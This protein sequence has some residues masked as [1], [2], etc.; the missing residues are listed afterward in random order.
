MKRAA[1]SFVL[2]SVLLGLSANWQQ[3]SFAAAKSDG[4]LDQIAS[5]VRSK[6]R[7]VVNILID[8]S[9]SLSDT[10]PGNQ[11]V[12][13]IK[14]ALGGLA[15]LAATP[16]SQGGA[17]VDVLLAGFDV[18]YYRFGEWTKISKDNLA[19][20]QQIADG[21]ASRN[22]G[23]DT[24][25]AAALIGANAAIAERSAEVAR[26]GSDAC[27]LLVWFTDGKY[28]I[29]DRT[30]A[31]R[32]RQGITKDYAPDLR[33]DRNGAGAELV[34]RGQRLL[35]DKAGVAD[36]MRTAKISTVVVAL[37]SDIAEPDRAFLRSVAGQDPGG[38]G[39]KPGIG[40]VVG[41][42][43]VDQV[44]T[45][46][47]SAVQEAKGGSELDSAGVDT[48]LCPRVAC[49]AGTRTFVIDP[50]IRQFHILAVT[51]G[52]DIAI[53]LQAP[54]SKSVLHLTYPNATR[55][56]VGAGTISSTWIAPNA[57]VI[58]AES[59]S[60]RPN[61]VG[62]WS[63]IFIDPKGSSPSAVS[64]S[65]IHVFGGLLPVLNGK[66]EFESGST[67]RFEVAVAGE[68]DGPRTDMRLFKTVR[69]R[70]TVTDPSSSFREE[71]PLQSTGGGFRG[72]YKP[73]SKIKSSFVNLTLRLEL[74]TRSGI[75]LAPVLRTY[76]VPVRPPASYPRL[77]PAEINFSSITGDGS[78]HAEVNIVG[79]KGP[80]CV[81][82]DDSA[83]ETF[84]TGISAAEFSSDPPMGSVD[85]CIKV[86]AGQ[87][88][89]VDLRV[90][91]TGQA[92]GVLSGDIVLHLQ[93][94]G[95]D[96]VL[97]VTQPISI[98]MQREINQVRR[99]EIFLLLL[100][101]GLLIPF[102]LLLAAKW[103]NSR[104][105]PFNSFRYL[106]VPIAVVGDRFEGREPG[107]AAPLPITVVGLSYADAHAQGD[108]RKF[109]LQELNFD[110][111]V[112][113][114][115]VKA[116]TG[117][118]SCASAIAI[119]G[120]GRTLWPSGD[121]DVSLAIAPSWLMVI[122]KVEPA[123]SNGQPARVAGSLFTFVRAPGS[124]AHSTLAE[125]SE[126]D[127]E[128]QRDLPTIIQGIIPRL[129]P[130]TVDSVETKQNPGFDIPTRSTDAHSAAMPPTTS[131]AS[132]EMP[133]RRDQ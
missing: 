103:W 22:T 78:A 25:Y 55:D 19:N 69:L 31:A 92:N 27:K 5:C 18:G 45:A 2:L 28:D 121:L 43:S 75:A 35:C 102:L 96:R 70:A 97:K 112:G 71:V 32:V 30:T 90:R 21:F 59:K 88:K 124:T 29:E 52:P 122:E 60:D 37:S 130:E 6:H 15:Q 67:K 14:A 36:Q 111:R 104:F 108:E 80:G 57:V 128:I 42:E 40:V 56:V 93:A 16:A 26:D 95:N 98:E 115:P 109:T 44:V 7:L 91:A 85:K 47:D 74:T 61:W 114:N 9:G 24:D 73:S 62:K 125:V 76:A 132:T 58:D 41:G 119:V 17:E 65:Q 68:R 33:L 79:G 72:D 107:T 39:A 53:D 131:E 77:D 49:A 133:P 105:Q 116:P 51:G 94:K 127:Q 84:P 123:T 12:S 20:L 4:A 81:W 99:I 34:A 63:A 118:I 48:S 110:A 54:G 87:R 64:H 8:Q 129:I 83:F 117:R 113:W 89:R 101:P 10:D 23:L 100:I 66:P 126:I 38:C 106:R 11:R 120:S 86:D 50:G 13:G 3:Q 82:I 1:V 46:F